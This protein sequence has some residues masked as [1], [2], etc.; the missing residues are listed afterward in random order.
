M[1]SMTTLRCQHKLIAITEIKY[2]HKKI[3]IPSFGKDVEHLDLSSGAIWEYKLLWKTFYY[4][5]MYLSIFSPGNSSSTPKQLPTG[6]KKY[7]YPQKGSY[8]NV[9]NSL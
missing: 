1:Q 7:I 9:Y 8:M 5:L 2:T 4:F 6:N 3:E